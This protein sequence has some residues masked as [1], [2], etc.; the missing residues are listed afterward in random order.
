[1]L[2]LSKKYKKVEKVKNSENPL[3]KFVASLSLLAYIVSASPVQLVAQEKVPSYHES[4]SK[5]T[6]ESTEKVI[7]SENGGV[8]ELGNA[9]IEIPSGAVEKDTVISIER[10]L[11]TEETGESIANV[12]PGKGCYRFLPKGTKFAVPV[13]I[14]L[15][16]D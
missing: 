15:P 4:S 12:L 16:Y 8:I 3:S 10:R 13:E 9:K 1:M 7:T 11:R 2:G 14:S 6:K 5:I